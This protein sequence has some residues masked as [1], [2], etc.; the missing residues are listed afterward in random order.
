MEELQRNIHS[1]YM[2]GL[3]MSSTR[4]TNPYHIQ[5]TNKTQVLQV[6]LVLTSQRD[7]TATV[8]SLA[9]LSSS[10]GYEEAF[11]SHTSE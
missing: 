7:C 2:H 4:E 6:S 8:Y 1:K 3:S 11:A 10:W 9:R 5:L